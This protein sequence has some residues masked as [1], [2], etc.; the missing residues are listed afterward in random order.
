MSFLNFQ[1]TF[2]IVKSKSKVMINY[3]PKMDN[4]WVGLLDQGCDIFIS[5]PREQNKIIATLDKMLRDHAYNT[6]L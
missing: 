6:H 4:I 1:N 2:F 5:S 3:V